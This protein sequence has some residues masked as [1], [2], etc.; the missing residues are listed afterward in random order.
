MS[1]VFFK[2]L[3]GGWCNFF[4]VDTGVSCFSGKNKTSFC[5]RSRKRRLASSWASSQSRVEIMVRFASHCFLVPQWGQNILKI[6]SWRWL[7]AKNIFSFPCWIEKVLWNEWILGTDFWANMAMKNLCDTIK[8]DKLHVKGLTITL[9][10]LLI[11]ILTQNS[12]IKSRSSTGTL[13]IQKPYKFIKKTGYRQQHLIIGGGLTMPKS[14][15][16]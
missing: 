10:K 1:L 14:I 7:E 11:D 16:V 2:N 15:T 9:F 12:I 4:Q 3:F 5:Q 8:I 6:R 13:S